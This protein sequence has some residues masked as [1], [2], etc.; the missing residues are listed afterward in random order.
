MQT[1][2]YKFID[3]VPDDLYQKVTGSAKYIADIKLPGMVYAKILRSPYSHARIKSIDTS[4]AEKLQGV[5]KIITG[6][7]CNI[8]FGTSIRDQSPLAIDKVRYGGEA[9]AAVIADS[10]RAAA[11]AMKK[12]RVHHE[13]LPH[14]TD[15]VEAISD[16]APVIHEKQEEYVRLEKYKPVKDTNIFHHY[17]L[18]RG[19]IE[20]AFEESDVI[21]DEKFHYPLLS[22][23]QLEPHGCICLWENPERL[24]VI[25]GTKGPFSLKKSLSKAFNIEE[26]H[27]NL[28]VPFMGGNFG[29]KACNSVI[30]LC[31]FISR[32]LIGHPVK[33]IMTREEVFTS[34]L[35]GR[36]MKGKIKIGAKKDGKLLALRAELFFACGA[37]GST[38]CSIVETGAIAATGP[39]EYEHY[40]IDSY[41]IYTNTPPLGAYRGFAHPET[42]LMSER[43]MDMLAG[44]LHMKTGALMKK[45]FLC[46]GKKTSTGQTVRG[47]QGNLLKC[48]EEIEKTLFSTPLPEED[49]RFLY[50]RGIASFIKYSSI[51]PAEYSCALLTVNDNG[52]FNIKVTGMDI[53]QGFINSLSRAASEILKVPSEKINVSLI[54]TGSSLFKDKDITTINITSR[55]VN[56]LINACKETVRKILEQASNI[57]GLPVSDLI[58]EGEEI[59]YRGGKILDIKDAGKKGFIEPVTCMYGTDEILTSSERQEN[60]GEYAFG[61]KG[62]EVKIDKKTGNIKVTHLIVA[63]DAGKIMNPPMARHQMVGGMIMGIGATLMEE[64][65]FD[66]YGKIKNASLN[67]YRI[68]TIRDMP[69]KLSVIFIETPD[70]IM[71]FQGRSIG[72]H[73]TIGVAPAI[74]NAIADATGIDFFKI[75]VKKEDILEKLEEQSLSYQA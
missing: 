53:G 65:L 49:S 29:G 31:A 71:P 23:V 72:E 7:D 37:Y 56:A 62:A 66:E 46:D 2:S 58:Y 44:K 9:V 17:K 55:C 26:E 4:G 39:Y 14:V 51:M 10:E 34:T 11:E 61:C 45:N 25:T 41:G 24:Q 8:M 42:H 67:S 52:K 69:E 33:L 64:L 16:Q 38:A 36:G 70:E 1:K 74:L 18:K 59:T 21:L 48:L 6:K 50:G 19:D 68:P 28:S 3:S 60:S 40:V 30:I 63:I 57:T 13:I 15:P 75:P 5:K 32:F 12:I 43:M 20:N 47:G 22:H 73:S 27:I 54:D 35:L